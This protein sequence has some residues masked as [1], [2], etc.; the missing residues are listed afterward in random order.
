MTIF[1]ATSNRNGKLPTK[2]IGIFLRR[3]TDFSFLR[4][5]ASKEQFK[6]NHKF[7]KEIRSPIKKRV[8][9]KRISIH[10]KSTILTDHKASKAYIKALR[11]L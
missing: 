10:I 11:R 7:Q 2:A 8:P 3:R 4:L 5:I 9:R 6:F 1:S